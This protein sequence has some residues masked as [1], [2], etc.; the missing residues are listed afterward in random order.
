MRSTYRCY[1]LVDEIEPAT[2][3]AMNYSNL[4]VGACQKYLHFFNLSRPGRETYKRKTEHATSSLDFSNQN[5]FLATGSWNREIN[6]YDLR[7][8]VKSSIKWKPSITFPKIHNSA[9]SRIK[10]GFSYM[11][12]SAG[13]RDGQINV[14]D[15]RNVQHPLFKLNREVETNQVI[16]FDLSKCD[17]MLVSGGSDGAV[18]TWDLQSQPNEN[19]QLRCHKVLIVCFFI[20]GKMILIM[21]FN[22]RFN[23]TKTAVVASLCIRMR[24]YWL[25]QLANIMRI[26]IRYRMLRTAL[27]CGGWVT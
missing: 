12:V 11:M 23:C 17:R 22:F 7:T 1:N 3:M 16:H 14:W 18:K 25:H 10:F 20:S 8:G 9:L 27:T 21:N 15:L 13:R 4:M 6:C 26:T 2:R 19:G 5:D 24:Q